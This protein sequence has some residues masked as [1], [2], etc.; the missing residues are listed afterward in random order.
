ML[1]DPETALRLGAEHL[2]ELRRQ[3]TLH[4]QTSHIV[5]AWRQTTGRVFLRL[6]HALLAVPSTPSPTPTAAPC[7]D[8]PSPPVRGL[9]R[10]PVL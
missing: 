5:P 2:Q 8:A 10:D 9:H 1:I 3:A 7:D 6:G 4:R